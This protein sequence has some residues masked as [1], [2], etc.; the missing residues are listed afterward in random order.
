MRDGLK[1]R[2]NPPKLLCTVVTNFKQRK[3]NKFKN[4]AG[5]WIYPPSRVT[6][7]SSKWVKTMEDMFANKHEKI[8]DNV[9]SMFVPA[10]TSGKGTDEVTDEKKMVICLAPTFNSL[11][12]VSHELGIP[13][14][15]F[16]EVALKDIRKSSGNAYSKMLS[17]CVKEGEFAEQ[18]SQAFT[19]FAKYMMAVE[20]D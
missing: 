14:T 16:T 2:I 5:T 15:M 11:Q 9:M 18:V 4:N 17:N 10:R 20:L 6:V 7:A 8:K 12:Q 13:V 1:F 19:S 3:P